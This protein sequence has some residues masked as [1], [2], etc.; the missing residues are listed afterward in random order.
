MARSR[1]HRRVLLLAAFA[2]AFTPAPLGVAV[3]SPAAAGTRSSL[4]VRP[5]GHGGP[6]A[7][8][9]STR[10]ATAPAPVPRA[11]SG[12]RD[13][14]ARRRWITVWRDDF[15]GRAGTPADPRFWTYEHGGWGWGNAE[16]QY[17]DTTP[18]AA[19]L[20][21]KG[22]LAI[23]AR[24]ASAGQ[25]CWYGPC[26]YTSARL[27]TEGKVAVRRG[28][29]E[30]RM[31]LPRGVGLWPAF[32]MLGANLRTAGWPYCGEIDIMEL[33]GD[34]PAR[35]WS[36]VH[37]P[38]YVRAGLTG[39]RTLP[40]PVTYADDFHTFAVEWSATRLVFLVDGRAYH[41][42]R[43]TDIGAGNEWVFDRP[44]HLLLNLAVGGSWPGDPD[45]HTVFP[46]TLLVDWV[47]VYRR[48]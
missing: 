23:V 18:A 39:N 5:A 44:F 30:A 45:E 24:R 31:R 41:T 35:V 29:I 15:R 46:A 6:G 36:S 38:G 11:T 2:A 12:A 7:A 43:R 17:Y 47:A 25:Q 33:V 9:T 32:W 22:R 3:L 37:G 13:G 8:A 34:D 4:A 14:A 28:R 1:R 20:D 26:R 27:T 19:A 10:S 21:G 48:R 42:V 16:L 40:A